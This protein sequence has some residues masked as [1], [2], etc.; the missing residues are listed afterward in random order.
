MDDKSKRPHLVLPKLPPRSNTIS[1][2]SS[3]NNNSERPQPPIPLPR[4]PTRAG[5]QVSS[6]SKDKRNSMSGGAPISPNR[7][8]PPILPDKPKLKS[9]WL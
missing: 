2:G 7:V 9:N 3:N 4:L 8:L 1:S 5:T 6:I